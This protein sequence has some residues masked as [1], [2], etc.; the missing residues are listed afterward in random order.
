MESVS[1]TMTPCM[2][3]SGRYYDR[4]L[5]STAH[6]KC[7]GVLGKFRCTCPHHTATKKR[8]VRRKARA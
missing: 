4:P 7:P 5:E 8:V 2:E 6:D 1:V 3:G